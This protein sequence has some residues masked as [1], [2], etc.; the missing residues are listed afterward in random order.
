MGKVLDWAEAAYRT[1]AVARFL[2]TT[3][4]CLRDAL[5]GC[6]TVLDLGCGA[7]SPV[8]GACRGQTV[9]VE[10]FEPALRSARCAGTHDAFVMADLATVEFGT[11]AVDAVVLVEVLEHLAKPDGL[12][13]LER[14]ERWARHKVVVTTPNGFVPQAALEGNPHQEHLSGWSVAEMQARGYRARGLAGLKHL[15]KENDHDVVQGD[16]DAMLA[17]I[18]LRPRPLWLGVSA[19]SQ[20]VTYR[21]PRLSFGV[22]YVR[23]A[24]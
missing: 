1:P 16:R 21:V 17:S 4:S 15:R 18:R 19:V 20:L 22:L 24:G 6:R 2:H 23:D 10:L 8:P 9:G 13:L 3:P 7:R 11:G 12:R 14:A 5:D